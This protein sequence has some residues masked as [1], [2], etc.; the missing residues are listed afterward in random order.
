[1]CF[2]G[3][4]TSSDT[5]AVPAES[6]PQQ[7]AIAFLDTW[8]GPNFKLARAA[9]EHLH[10]KQAAFVF[11][12]LTAQ[13]GAASV[14]AVTT[15]LDRIEVLRSGSDP[16]RA[17]S[18]DADRQAVETLVTRKILTPEIEA[19][20]RGHLET[21]SSL[22]PPPVQEEEEVVDPAYEKVAEQFHAWL[23]DWRTTARHAIT[24]RDHQIE[25]GLTKR[26]SSKAGE[27]TEDDDD[28]DEGWGT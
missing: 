4:D 16:S 14:G 23:V 20:L 9:L 25:L 21:A 22:A 12:G 3:A 13:E 7:K 8:D 24:R 10:P 27:E 1:M 6:T 28:E 11:T 15:F 19:E 18:R 2:F 26:R 5:P 17:S